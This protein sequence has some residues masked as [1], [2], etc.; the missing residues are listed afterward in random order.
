MREAPRYLVVEGPLGSGTTTLATIIS[1]E[2]G[3]ELVLD[4]HEDNPYLARFYDDPATHALPTQLS[5]LHVRW[6]QQ[7]R[8]AG[9]L[10]DQTTVVSDYFFARDELYA[11]MTLTEEEYAL[12][13]YSAGHLQASPPVPDLVI[14]LQATAETLFKRISQRG[15]RYEEGLRV[16]YLRR[17]T[18]V[19]N[20]FFFHYDQTPLL[21]VN[22]TDIDYVNS[23]S[24]LRYL[25]CE[26]G[27]I[28][29]GTRY[30]VASGDKPE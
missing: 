5:F 26:I 23:A 25:L 28:R 21:V 7:K 13:E 18:D 30:Y 17:L 19:Y 2:L 6:E 14:Y 16:D 22:T 11:Q 8:L 10:G 1:N 15:R 12:Y 24:E 27:R 20:Q 29:A 9:T 3:Y 4:P